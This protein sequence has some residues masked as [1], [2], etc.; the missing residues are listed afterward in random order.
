MSRGRGGRR[1]LAAAVAALAMLAGCQDN[2]WWEY[3]D[4]PYMANIAEKGEQEVV[5]GIN[6]QSKEQRMTALRVAAS[7]AGEY[8]LQGDTGTARDLEEIIIRRYFVEREQEVRACIVQMC[9]PSVGRSG[10]MVRFLRERIAAGEF[11]GYAAISLASL[12]PRSA[13]EDIEPLTRHPAPDVRLQAATALTILADPRG[14][15]SVLKVWKGMES[16]LWPD[17][18]EG[19]SRR[20]ARRGLE[21]RALRA[22]GKP[23]Q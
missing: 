9:A 18:M 10:T 11:P 13:F 4:D 1:L 19:V 8:R 12:G 21:A 22:F 23:L 3:R 6:S 17:R 20:E 5:R 7:R 16:T 14:Y 15:D 2:M